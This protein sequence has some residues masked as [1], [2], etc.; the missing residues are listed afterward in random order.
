MPGRGTMAG[1]TMQQK[2]R[3]LL[4]LT[5]KRAAATWRS[6]AGA[7]TTCPHPPCVHK[8]SM[9][10]AAVPLQTLP[11]V[12]PAVPRGKGCSSRA[13]RR[14]AQACTSRT[15]HLAPGADSLVGANFPHRM[16]AGMRVC[17][18]RPGTSFKRHNSR[19]G[20]PIKHCDSGEGTGEAGAAYSSTMQLVSSVWLAQAGDLAAYACS[21]THTWL[22]TAPAFRCLLTA[23]TRW[24]STG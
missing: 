2:G 1:S 14:S 23:L 20:R 11:L 4:R 24:L 17:S 9:L 8:P 6:T 22:V 5:S 19:S 7:N 18:A 16:T 12:M 15:A 10:T 3:M 13:P 21:C